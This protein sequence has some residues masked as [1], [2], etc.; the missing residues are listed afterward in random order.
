MT[1]SSHV[2]NVL[3]HAEG[4]DPLCL[5]GPNVI[6]ASELRPNTW[7]LATVSHEIRTPM[8]GVLGMLQMLMDTNLDDSQMDFAQTAHKSGKDL[9]SVINEVLYQAKIEA[10]KLELEAVAF[11]PHAI[12]DEVQSLF[13]ENSNEKGI[14]L[15]V[16]ASSQVPKVVIGDP[17]RFWQIITNLVGNALKFTHNQGH[18]FVLSHQANEVKNQLNVT[19]KVLREGLMNQDISERT[20]NNTLSGFPV[21]NRWKRWEN[22]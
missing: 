5:W 7:F 13:S 10:G 2:I 12:L 20:C 11:H 1:W 14:E 17:K 22:F 8:N 9:I 18:V 21:G 16:Y 19:D 15:A 3:A 6:R 4:H